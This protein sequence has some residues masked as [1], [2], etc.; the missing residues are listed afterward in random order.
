MNYLLKNVQPIS[1]NI[2]ATEIIKTAQQETVSHENSI[3]YIKLYKIM[4]IDTTKHIST[5]LK[6]VIEGGV[7]KIIIDLIQLSFI[8][9]TGI[10][11][12][13]NSAKMIRANKGDIVLLNV[14]DSIEEIFEPVNLESFIPFYSEKLEAVTFLQNK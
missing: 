2:I 8:D 12:L 13:I 3:M 4:D 11:I 1:M 14:S 5:F 9:S 10:G 7:T 6:T